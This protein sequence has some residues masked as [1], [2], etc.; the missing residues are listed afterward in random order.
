LDGAN[1]GAVPNDQKYEDRLSSQES[2][3]REEDG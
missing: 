3:D 1:L 2:K